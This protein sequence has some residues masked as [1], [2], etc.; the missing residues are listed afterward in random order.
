[1]DWQLVKDSVG[2]QVFFYLMVFGAVAKG[3]QWAVEQRRLKKSAARDD[4]AAE[5]TGQHLDVVDDVALVGAAM[6]IVEQLQEQV[7][8][9]DQ[10]HSVEL[11]ALHR[12]NSGLQADLDAAKEAHQECEK[13]RIEQ[14][15]QIQ[16]LQAQVRM[17]NLAVKGLQKN[18][19]GNG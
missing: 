19:E 14:G 2:A 15:N 7:R 16:D 9:Q 12:Q 11:D 5:R 13:D 8:V 3:I 1:M 10:R 18:G 17:L 6:Q 4:R